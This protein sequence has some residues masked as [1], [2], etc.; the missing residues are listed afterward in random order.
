MFAF[1][2]SAKFVMLK[3]GERFVLLASNFDEASMS[4][5]KLKCVRHT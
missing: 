5:L 1:F 3:S 2:M 4:G